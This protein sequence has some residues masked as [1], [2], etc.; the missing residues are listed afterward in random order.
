M[1]FKLEVLNQKNAIEAVRIKAEPPELYQLHYNTHWIGHSYVHDDLSAVL[2]RDGEEAVGFV[3]YGQSYHDAYLLE[4]M[5]DSIAEIHHF[6]IKPG[7]Q[8]QG[9]GRQT[10]LAIARE[11]HQ[12]NYKILRVAHHPEADKARAFYTN[13]GFKIIGK[14]YDDDPL[15][16]LD[17]EAFLSRWS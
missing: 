3:C 11:M 16:E 5:D 8:G 7:R 12:K 9:F 14:S 2:I 1:T 10:V 17:L 6:L 15:L 4:K 13:L